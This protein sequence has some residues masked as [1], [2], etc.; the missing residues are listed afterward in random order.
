MEKSAK[1]KILK[2]KIRFD[3]PTA[4]FVVGEKGPESFPLHWHNAAEF[5][6]IL[7]DNCQY[8]VNDA[9]YSLSAG[10]VVLVWPQQ[11]HETIRIPH[12]GAVFIQFP[13]AI[14]ENNLDLI[15]ISGF[16]YDCNLISSKDNSSLAASIR[17]KIME[18]KRIYDESDFLSETRCKLCIYEILIKVG[19]H[20]FSTVRKDLSEGESKDQ[21]WQYIHNACT[22]IVENITEDI[23]Q[24]DV[25][26]QIGLSSFY[27]S[28]LFKKYMHMSFPEYMANVRV[29]KAASLLLDADISITDCAFLSGFQSTTTFNKAFHNVTG[30]SPRDFRKMFR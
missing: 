2:E 19:E 11:I 20:V 24:A 1:E 27:F 9:I 8:R 15:A 16:L 14:L 28:K 23:S 30:F 6:L 4:L 10:D 18:I 3:S 5:T 21:G 7:E 13:S 25:A 29:K 17:D 12:G 22:Y 26:S